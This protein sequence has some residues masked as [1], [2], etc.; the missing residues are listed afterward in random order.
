[1][2]MRLLGTCVI[3]SAGA[4][5]AGYVCSP[6]P[7]ENTAKKP[8]P[9]RKPP[10]GEMHRREPS[11]YPVL[12]PEGMMPMPIAYNRSKG[13]P[14]SESS[15]NAELNSS[16]TNLLYNSGY[17]TFGSANIIGAFGSAQVCEPKL[18]P[19]AYEIGGH[20]LVELSV[21]DA[22]GKQIVEVGHIVGPTGAGD[23]GPQPTLFVF[24]WVDGKA[25]CYNGC[26]W[27]Q[28]SKSVVPGMYEQVSSDPVPVGYEYFKGDWWVWYDGEAI[29]YFP[30]SLWAHAQ[31][32]FRAVGFAQW[33]GEVASPNTKPATQMG[34]GLFGD[35]AGACKWSGLYY[36][37]GT[38][39]STWASDL[40]Y[41]VTDPSLYRIGGKGIDNGFAL[42]GPGS[43]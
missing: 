24:H 16:A 27:V 38:N 2:T 5:H 43:V 19:R 15:S 30:G 40:G 18:E 1:M 32:P 20:S 8:P 22:K 6:V 36:V 39:T 28:V 17:K 29:G 11:R 12:C 42:G 9:V 26:G 14:S 13:R 21:E 41:T 37:D 33:F 34:D 25:G 7:S 31:T 3:I 35:Q 23:K 4:S 10:A